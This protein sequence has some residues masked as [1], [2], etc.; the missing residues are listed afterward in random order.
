MKINIKDIGTLEKDI[1]KNSNTD[2]PVM[3]LDTSGVIDI[4]SASRQYNL[5][6]KNGDKNLKYEMPIVFLKNLAEKTHVIITPKIY[7]EIQDHGR[8]RL[9]CHTFELTP[10]IVDFALDTMTDSIRF[11]SKLNKNIELD[12]A[13]YDAYWASQEGC[14][15][16]IKKNVEGCSDADKEIL[17]TAALLSR[18]KTNKFPSKKISQVIVLSSDAHIIQGAEFLK[19]SFDGK[20]SNII[21]ISTRYK[22]K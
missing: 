21:P 22:P 11:I 17:S 6:N 13:R 4:V 2:F 14:K 12:Q 15:E 5:I 18:C 1:L 10:K 16:N 8:M 3:L 9:N 19:R 7:Q 20:Y